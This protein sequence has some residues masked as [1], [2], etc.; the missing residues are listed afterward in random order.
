MISLKE[1][2]CDLEGRD[3]WQLLFKKTLI[4]VCHWRGLKNS[5]GNRPEGENK[6]LRNSLGIRFLFLVSHISIYKS[7]KR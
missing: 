6:I 5:G 1:L 2:T 4:Y 3:T 7:N